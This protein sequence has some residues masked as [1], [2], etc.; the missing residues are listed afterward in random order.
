MLPFEVGQG[1]EH[2][3]EF[4]RQPRKYLSYIEITYEPPMRDA[5]SRLI[6]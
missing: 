4:I 6:A 3:S 2:M 1:K 5:A